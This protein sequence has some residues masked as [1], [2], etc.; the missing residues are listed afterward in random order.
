MGEVFVKMFGFLCRLH[1]SVGAIL[2]VDFNYRAQQGGPKNLRRICRSCVAAIFSLLFI[3]QEYMVKVLM[4]RDQFEF[5]TFVFKTS[6][7]I[8]RKQPSGILNISMPSLS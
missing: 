1:F 5:R 3:E 6:H 8:R 7:L 2:A 4:V